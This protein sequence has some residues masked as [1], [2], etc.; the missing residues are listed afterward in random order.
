MVTLRTFLADD[1][2]PVQPVLSLL[3]QPVESGARVAKDFFAGIK[4][5]LATMSG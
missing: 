1:H 4:A 3:G 5:K 2:A